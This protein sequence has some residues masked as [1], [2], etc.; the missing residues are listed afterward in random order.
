MSAMSEPKTEAIPA[1]Q[2]GVVKFFS[3]EKGF[4]FIRCLSGAEIFVHYSDI[5]C[6]G[7]R[8]LTEGEPVEFEIAESPKGPKAINVR[9]LDST[10]AE[11]RATKKPVT[12]KRM[13][14]PK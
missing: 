6:E 10:T 13:A 4:G 2:E 8:S 5:D 7:Y 3:N 11:P 12:F 9:S 1:V 14:D